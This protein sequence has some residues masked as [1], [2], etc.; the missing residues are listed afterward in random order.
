MK[1]VFY[2]YKQQENN[3]TR[4][5]FEFLS[6]TNRRLVLKKFLKDICDIEFEGNLKDI[7]FHVQKRPNINL[8]S[9]KRKKL[10]VI[11]PTGRTFKEERKELKKDVPD[12]WIW[13]DDFIIA[14]ENKIASHGASEEQINRYKN[15]I[16]C[17]K[18]DIIKLAWY[19]KF[20]KFIEDSH[21]KF[22]SKPDSK[23]FYITE[24]LRKFLI[25]LGLGPF[26]GFKKE[27]FKIFENLKKNERKILV[28]E[29]EIPKKL[30]TIAKNLEYDFLKRYGN[31]KTQLSDFTGFRNK[32]LNVWIS[33]TEYKDKIKGKKYSISNYPHFSFVIDKDNISFIIYYQT[34]SGDQKCPF[35]KI[36]KH[37]LDNFS[38]FYRILSKL[39]KEYIISFE[40]KDEEDFVLTIKKSDL[41]KSVNKKDLRDLFRIFDSI[42]Y[43][44]V[45]GRRI[46]KDRKMVRNGKRLTTK[47]RYDIKNLSK[48][49]DFL[50]NVKRL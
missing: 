48:V 50:T 43:G 31:I 24:E 21:K 37:I 46:D 20:F 25:E 29:Q 26:D 11:S 16:S 2:S 4:V 17:S 49:Y 18:K 38:K 7:K 1:P 34:Y 32:I 23:D 14:V 30:K 15:L 27:D 3:L 13:C 33:Y 40:G 39:P 10:V 9:N 41:E 22:I 19:Y 8:K 44:L 12:G 28:R 42:G 6:K 35:H 47:F 45:I 5:L 36:N